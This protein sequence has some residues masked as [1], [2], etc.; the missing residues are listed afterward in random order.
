MPWAAVGGAVAAGGSILSGILGG[1]AAKSAANQQAQQ[2]RNTLDWIRNVYGQAGSNL[3]PF[4]GTGADALAA[5]K[6]FYG[7]PGGNVG[8]AGQAF[9]SF[10]GTPFYQFPLAQANLATNRAMVASGLIGLMTAR[11]SVLAFLAKIY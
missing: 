4:I 10:Q 7:L 5:L 2:Q 11:L 3:Q 9:S 8:S 1:S 6:G